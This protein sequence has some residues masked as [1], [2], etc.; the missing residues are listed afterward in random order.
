MPV[1]CNVLMNGADE[2]QDKPFASDSKT[3]PSGQCVD[4]W[5]GAWVGGTEVVPARRG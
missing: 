1:D 3:V 4:C 2:T 5:V